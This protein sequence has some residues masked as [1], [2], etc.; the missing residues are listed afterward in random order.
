VERTTKYFI[1][2]KHQSVAPSIDAEL[3]SS[4]ISS[5]KEELIP[6]FLKKAFKNDKDD[7]KYYLILADSGMGKTTFM[8]NLYI[9]YKN[10]F[11]FPFAPPKYDIKLFP[12]GNP[13]I[14]EDIKGVK[15]KKNTILLLDAFDEDLEAI[16]DHQKRLNEIL[17]KVHKF[18][19]IVITCR[20]QFFPSE[21]EEPD[22]TGY[23]TGDEWH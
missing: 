5:P 3:G 11:R 22:R 13:D 2:V 8:I 7:N 17:P 15:D 1:P 20:T 19:E 16:K 18:R 9:R 12:L 6:F 4:Y 10:A 23:F 21:K 14:W